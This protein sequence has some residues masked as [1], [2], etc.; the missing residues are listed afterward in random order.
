M[1]DQE[2][3]SNKKEKDI[4]LVEERYGFVKKEWKVQR[5]FQVLM[6]LFLAA[7]LM[8]LFGKGVLSKKTISHEGLDIEYQQYVR[9]KT[10][11][12]LSIYLKNPL[13]TTV[14]SFNSDY[15]RDVRIDQ[16]MPQPIASGT[17]NN[18]SFFTFNT[19]SA[20]L[21]T[22]YIFPEH[23]GPLNLNLQ[24]HKETKHLEQFVYF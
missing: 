16:M 22:F 23:M 17:E 21:I 12:K 5:A 15:L 9:V 2:K 8:G 6:L 7:G 24:I 14:I 13:D 11:T 20:G 4:Q 3:G 18:R 1:A 10:P 19:T